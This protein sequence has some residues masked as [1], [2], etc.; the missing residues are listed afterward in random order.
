MAQMA[1]RNT[2]V[3]SDRVSV[4]SRAA[5]VRAPTHVRVYRGRGLYRALVA[6]FV[7]VNFCSVSFLVFLFYISTTIFIY[8]GLQ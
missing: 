7:W 3:Q 5:C 2:I 4:L 8:R 1:V 6:P